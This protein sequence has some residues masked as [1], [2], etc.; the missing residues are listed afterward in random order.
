MI[1]TAIQKTS[2]QL[3]NYTFRGDVSGFNS[4]ASWNSE[5]YRERAILLCL[6]PLGLS[7]SMGK[8]VDPKKSPLRI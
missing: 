4:E 5:V 6:K 3:C 1:C 2:K 7:Q 8:P